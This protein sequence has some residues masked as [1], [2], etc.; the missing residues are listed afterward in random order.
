MSSQQAINMTRVLFPALRSTCSGL[1]LI[2]I[3]ALF[4]VPQI[5]A[6]AAPYKEGTHYQRLDKPVRTSDPR[7]IEVAEVFWYGCSHCFTFEPMAREWASKLPKDVS[8]VHSPAIWHPTME[9]HARAYYTAKA[10]KALDQVHIPLFEALNLQKKKLASKAAI[11]EIFTSA[12]VE[13]EKFDKTFDSFGVTSAVRQAD[14]RQRGFKTEGTPEL[15][16]NGKYRINARMGG[17]HGGML[18]VASYLIEQERA[19]IKAKSPAATE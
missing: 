8:F 7:R 1:C 19:L 6:E 13:Q 18:E 4:V 11:G 14:A 5:G 10:L 12:G 9:L 17:G 2:L 16:V 3:G 15:V